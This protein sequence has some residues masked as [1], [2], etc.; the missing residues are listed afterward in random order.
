MLFTRRPSRYLLDLC[1]STTTTQL[2]DTNG[3]G[4]VSLDEFVGI[5]SKT[6]LHRSIPFNF[7]CDFVKLYFGREGK[8]DITYT[9]FRSVVVVFLPSHIPQ[10]PV[11][12]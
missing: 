2:F 7:D 11:P 9:E 5:L 3:N 10:Q 12:A 1:L 8:R 6:T 4:T